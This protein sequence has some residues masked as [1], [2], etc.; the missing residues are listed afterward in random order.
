MKKLILFLAMVILM[1]SFVSADRTLYETGAIDIP[2][3]IIAGDTFGANFSFKYLD[4]F[5]NPDSSPLI[6]Q[7]NFSSN[8]E[9]YPVWRNDF[10]VSGRIEKY[11]LWGYI[12][13]GTVEFDCDNSEVQVINHPLDSQTISEINNGTFYCY[14]ENA[15]LQLE[16]YDE[17]Y[18]DIVSHYALY[19]GEYSLTA[20]MF[21]LND[22]RAPT[23][24]IL[25]KH[26]FEST[27]FNIGN[28][29]TV[30]ASIEDAGGLKEN[31]YGAIVS[32]GTIE[33]FR[34]NGHTN[35]GIYYFPWT[36]SSSLPEGE[37]NLS[38][39]AEDVSSNSANDTT[40][41]M[42]DRTAPTITLVQPIESTYSDMI[43]I[44]MEITDAKSRVDDSSVMY[45]LSGDACKIEGEGSIDCYDGGW[46]SLPYNETRGT[47][48]I[49]AD[50]TGE[51]IE[52]G[53]YWIMVH[54]SDILGNQGVLE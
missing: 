23:V 2:L 30:I 33:L 13:V 12:H 26:I 8:N 16:E 35:N 41:L 10:E 45:R 22:T 6:I 14:D 11:A 21:Y 36:I 17:V 29:I 24:L 48:Y 32:N 40:I 50:I 19:P 54:A 46:Q 9:D 44:E 5:S 1:F 37:Y 49:E 3:D 38:I 43:P 42:I 28:S 25:N 34:F 51:T 18:L 53:D 31:G 52:D 4:D 27:Y 15:D 7:L 39:F 20:S 47:Y